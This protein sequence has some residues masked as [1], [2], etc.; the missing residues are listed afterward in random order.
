MGPWTGVRTRLSLLQSP[1]QC[2]EQHACSIHNWLGLYDHV[3]DYRSGNHLETDLQNTQG[4][5]EP[6]VAD[7]VSYPPPSRR[8]VGS[9]SNAKLLGEQIIHVLQGRSTS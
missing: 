8:Y 4:V 7:I 9:L 1:F 2:A 6:W 3:G 5:E